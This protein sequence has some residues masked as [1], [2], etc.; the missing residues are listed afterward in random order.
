MH[1]KKIYICYQASVN[2]LT[3]GSLPFSI[4]GNSERI[5]VHPKMHTLKK[6][7]ISYCMSAFELGLL[8]HSLCCFFE[9]VDS[10][11][12]CERGFTIKPRVAYHRANCNTG[13]R[14]S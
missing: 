13:E 8:R 2:V 6:V 4:T 5:F 11:K 10:V 7:L 1:T 14:R 12:K 3:I 9:F